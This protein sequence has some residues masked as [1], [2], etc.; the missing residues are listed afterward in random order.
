[1][2][3]Q[4]YLDWLSADS[5]RPSEAL[6]NDQR[7]ALQDHL[8]ACPECCRLAAA[9]QS[10]EVELQQ[11]PFSEPAP[12][13]TNR[14]RLHLEAS[15][16]RQH[17]RQSMVI[18][19]AS[20][21]LALLLLALLAIQVWPIFQS[22]RLLLLTYL[23]QVFRWASVLGAVQQFLGSM[24]QGA[25]LSLSPLGWMLA[26]GGLTLLVVLWV[27]SYRVLTS[28]HSIPIRSETK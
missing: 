25:A 18:F 4:P 7:A 17:R 3:H 5:H 20:L 26:A 16:Q 14:W 22:P 8:D 23:Y 15:R 10:V 1:M 11:A 6:S 9:W 21:G 28:P 27:V 12:G 24:L 19:A 2:T 13:F